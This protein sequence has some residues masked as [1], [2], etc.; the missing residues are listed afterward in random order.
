MKLGTLVHYY[1]VP[2]QRAHDALGDTRMLAGVLAA[3]LGSVAQLAMPLPFVACPPRQNSYY[4]PPSVPKARCAFGNP[5]PLTDVLVQGM[6][7]AITGETATPRLDLIAR[8]VGAGLNVMNNVSKHT[9]VLVTN[10]D[11]TGTTK[12]DNARAA[13][14]PIVDEPTF[15]RLL[16]QVRPGQPLGEKRARR[17]PAPRPAPKPSGP[18]A[19][20]RVLV[21]GGPHD[22]A[23]ELRVKIAELGGAASVNLSKSVTDVL[24]LEDGDLDRRI[25]KI[26]TLGL[27]LRTRDWLLDPQAAPVESAAAQVLCRGAVIDL[28]EPGRWTISA[29]WDH[30][31]ACEIDLVAFAVDT[32]GQVSTDEDF[33]FY[34]APES[35]DGTI[36]LATNGP[37][38]QA[39]TIDLDALPLVVQK[40]VVAASIDGTSTFGDVGAVEIQATPG[41]ATPVAEATL[42]AATTE[43]T[44][45]LTEIY[46]REDLWRLR[47]VGQGYDHDLASLAR[48]YGVD[49]VE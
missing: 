49:V 5:G 26:R 25:G 3:S 42:D 40:I 41:T 16:E 1:G 23:A 10:D 45:I 19:G 4:F 27:P 44:L 32:D 46:R 33:V 31:T 13:G 39:I 14:V 18:L 11:G 47:A 2:P 15:L 43:K 9:S 8:S 20:H 12:A 37:A 35:P 6:K 30:Q 34:G 21:L 28:P 7:V 38:E 24:L 17:V 48:S 22:L 36:T 29:S